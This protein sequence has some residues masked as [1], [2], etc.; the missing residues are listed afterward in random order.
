MATIT[1]V[2]P[3]G[4]SGGEW[5]KNRVGAHRPVPYKVLAPHFAQLRISLL[6]HL[7]RNC[8]KTDTDFDFFFSVLSYW[9][10]KMGNH[11]ST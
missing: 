4:D 1:K 7:D 5:G 11:L 10:I 3:E 6:E 9:V 8:R 2:V